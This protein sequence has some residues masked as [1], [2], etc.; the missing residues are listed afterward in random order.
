MNRFRTITINAIGGNNT[1]TVNSDSVPTYLFGANGND[2]FTINNQRRSA[3]HRRSGTITNKTDTFAINANSGILT[4]TMEGGARLNNFTITGNGGNLTISGSGKG[5]TCLVNGNGG[6]LTLNGSS[7]TD[8][9]TVNAIETPA[10][11]NGGT[12]IE[13]RTVNAPLASTG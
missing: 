11:I 3:L 10:T 12:G 9:F 5:N 2:A 13:I 8:S 6:Q 4:I 1:F 7:T